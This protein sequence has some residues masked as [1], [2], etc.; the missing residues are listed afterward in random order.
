MGFLP[1]DSSGHFSKSRYD[2][3]AIYSNLLWR[4][5][6]LSKTE[7]PKGTVIKQGFGQLLWGEDDGGGAWLVFPSE[8]SDTMI[9]GLSIDQSD[10]LLRWGWHKCVIDPETLMEHAEYALT[11]GNR[12]HV[13]VTSVQ[14]AELLWFQREGDD[15]LEWISA[16][17]L[18][19]GEPPDRRNSPIRWLKLSEVS[20]DIAITIERYVPS[21]PAF[22]T[23]ARVDSVLKEIASQSVHVKHVRCIVSINSESLE[24]HVE[25]GERIGWSRKTHATLKTQSTHE[26]VRFLRQPIRTGEYI[27]SADGVLLKWDHLNDVEFKYTT[28]VRSNQEEEE[29]TMS[30]LKPLIHRSRFFPEHYVVPDTCRELLETKSKNTVKLVVHV[31]EQRL[32]IKEF[33]CL[34]VKFDGL[35]D[36]SRIKGLERRWMNI[37]DVALLAECEEIVDVDNGSRHA[38]TLELEE[39]KDLEIPDGISD[40]PRLYEK[41][42]SSNEEHYE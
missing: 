11:K 22:D 12:L 18:E 28:L 32:S 1:K 30:F 31:D 20:E 39:L 21:D 15:G 16:G 4:A 9:A 17:I 3:Q 7:Q 25:L 36:S 42:S 10:N 19:Y 6:V 27:E 2:F 38:L 35:S 37:Y 24:Y 23:E 41:L 14:D 33:R 29:L 5:K 40:Y 13:A 26:L 34:R 8:K